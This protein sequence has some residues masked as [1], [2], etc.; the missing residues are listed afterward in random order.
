MAEE[1]ELIVRVDRIE[2]RVVRI[3]DRVVRIEDRVAHIEDRVAHIQDRVARIDE[4]VDGFTV[5][6]DAR[7]SEF[8]HYVDARFSD[9]DEAIA[10]Q[11]RYTEFAF[12]RLTSAMEAGFNRVDVR[13]GQLDRKLDRFIDTYE[14]RTRPRRRG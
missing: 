11:R 3:E 4:K 14:Q 7:F 1:N 9:V 5:S 10:E 8:R 12:D 2:D 6:T 13:F